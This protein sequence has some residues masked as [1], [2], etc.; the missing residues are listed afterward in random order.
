MQYVNAEKEKTL[1][2]EQPNLIHV[3]K[4]T[5]AGLTDITVEVMHLVTHPMMPG[6]LPTREQAR[7]SCS[8]LSLALRGLKDARLNFFWSKL[9]FKFYQHRAPL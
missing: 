7:C 2:Q 6:F 9:S 8:V 4:P 1:S 5:V 3:T